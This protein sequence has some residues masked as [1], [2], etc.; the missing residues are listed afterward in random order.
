MKTGRKIGK[1]KNFLPTR[2]N[3]TRVRKFKNKCEKILTIKKKT[4]QASFQDVTDKVMLKNRE[5]KKFPSYQFDP[6]RFRKFTNKCKKILKII[7]HH[8]GFISRRNG[9]GQAEK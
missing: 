7:K 4:L 1:K 6:S 8:P 5:Q 3:P 2:S 9:S